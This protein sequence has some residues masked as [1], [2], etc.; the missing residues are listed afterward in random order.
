MSMI[1]RGEFSIVNKIKPFAERTRAIST[2]A[3][4]PYIIKSPV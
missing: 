1:L 4:H 3:T 2:L